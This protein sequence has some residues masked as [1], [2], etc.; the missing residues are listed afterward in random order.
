MPI[1][2]ERFS[3]ST[4]YQYY[5]PLGVDEFIKGGL[6]RWAVQQGVETSLESA[7]YIDVD[8]EAISQAV[9]LT[10]VWDKAYSGDGWSETISLPQKDSTIE[11]GVLSHEPNT[12]PEDY[13]FGGFLTALG[14]DSKPRNFPPNP[15]SQT[16]L[17]RPQNRHVSKHPHDTTPSSP[18]R[19]TTPTPH[20][21]SPP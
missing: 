8:Y 18:P 4:A 14:Q 9:V 19:P 16:K 5:A 11:I 12:D 2:S 3:M 20:P 17:T 6:A 13:Q 7:S 21:R 1:L 10:A 15:P